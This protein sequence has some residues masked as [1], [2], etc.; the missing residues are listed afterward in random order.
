MLSF[1]VLT[2]FSWNHTMVWVRRDIKAPLI[3]PPAID[4][5]TFHYPRLLWAPS[6]LGLFPERAY[7]ELWASHSTR[8][9]SGRA[10]GTACHPYRA[11]WGKQKPWQL[12]PRWQQCSCSCPCPRGGR[13]SAPGTGWPG[14]GSSAGPAGAGRGPAAASSGCSAPGSAPGSSAPPRPPAPPSR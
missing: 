13:A 4:Q 2:D 8:S 6:R 5:D 10:V 14:G 9:P 1:L 3:P 12:L 11:R 7:P